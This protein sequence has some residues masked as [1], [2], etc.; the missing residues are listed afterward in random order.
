[1]HVAQY[2]PGKESLSAGCLQHPGTTHLPTPF[3]RPLRTTFLISLT[4]FTTSV[5]PS[6]NRVHSAPSHH[7]NTWRLSETTANTQA[8]ERCAGWKLFT[9]LIIF[10][11]HT[12]AVIK[13]INDGSVQC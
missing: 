1:M 10:V 2:L 8:S 7:D 12:L 3:S 6:A 11:K 13:Y 5:Y 4:V 9:N